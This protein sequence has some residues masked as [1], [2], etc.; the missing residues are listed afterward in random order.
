MVLLDIL[1]NENDL[2]NPRFHD[3]KAKVSIILCRFKIILNN[4]Q[5]Y[6]TFQSFY[7]L[8]IVYCEING[9]KR[10]QTFRSLCNILQ[11]ALLFSCLTT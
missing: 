4:A 1:I 9:R 11:N 10:F 3:L 7:Y 6:V 8:F 2:A 5:N